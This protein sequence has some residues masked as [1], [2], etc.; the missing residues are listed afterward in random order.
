M[1]WVSPGSNKAMIPK[2]SNLGAT[3]Q[4]WLGCFQYSDPYSNGTVDEFRIYNQ[5]LTADEIAVLAQ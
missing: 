5:A 3:T 1:E 4:N 2:P